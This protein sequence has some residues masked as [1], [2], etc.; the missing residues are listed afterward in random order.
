MYSVKAGGTIDEFEPYRSTMS[1]T[2]LQTIPPNQRTWSRWQARSLPTHAG[3][4]THTK[5][6]QVTPVLFEMTVRDV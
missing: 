6:S 1:A 3:A 5:E 2:W 4:A